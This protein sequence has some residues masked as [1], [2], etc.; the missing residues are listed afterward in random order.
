MYVTNGES[1]TKK[2]RERD[3]VIRGRGMENLADDLATISWDMYGLGTGK[4][5]RLREENSCRRR[6]G[7]KDE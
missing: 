7:I 4:G 1:L 2:K 6:H 5:V 3:S